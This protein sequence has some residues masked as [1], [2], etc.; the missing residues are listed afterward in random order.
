MKAFWRFSIQLG[1][2]ETDSQFEASPAL[3]ADPLLSDAAGEIQRFQHLGTGGLGG[4][5]ED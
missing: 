5:W 3:V 2:S 1:H 4:I